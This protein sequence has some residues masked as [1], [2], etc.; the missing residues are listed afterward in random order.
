MTSSRNRKKIK[1]RDTELIEAINSGRHE[2][3]QE[4]VQRYEQKVYNFGLRMC[5][6]VYDAEDVVQDTFLNVFKYL[7]DFRYETKFKNWLYRI[8]TS[9]CIKKRRRSKFAPERE[10]SLEEFFP[11]E[12]ATG[13][14]EIP[15]WA[16]LPLDQVLNEELSQHLKAAILSLPEKYRVIVI[17]RDVEGFSTAETSQILELKTLQREGQTSQGTS[18]SAGSIKRVFR[19]WHLMNTTISTVWRCLRNCPNISM[20]SW[21]GRPA[22]KS[23]R[24]SRPAPPARP[25]LQPSRRLSTCAGVSPQIPFLKR[26]PKN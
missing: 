22:E 16:Q 12:D 1:D 9:T 19:T 13:P 24:I 18:V 6:D 17:L 8:A 3:F 25:A 4:L 20:E 23:S 15:D 10:L 14:N 5:G 2:Q 7:K 11:D 21:I 26:Y